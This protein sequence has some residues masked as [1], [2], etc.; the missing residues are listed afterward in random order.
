MHRALAEV[1]D[2]DRRAWHLASASTGPDEQ[3]AA[4]L[5]RT[6]ESARSR[7]G[8]AAVAAAY[9][10]AA[11]LSAHPRERGR[12]LV[13]AARAAA[14]AGQQERAA[15]LA[16]DAAALIT[17]PVATA[18]VAKF[19][20]SLADERGSATSAHQLLAESAWAV[21][22][23]TPDLA[24]GLL[25][26]A[27][28]IAWTAGDFTAVRTAADQAH[29]LR[30]PD[31]GR[32]GELAARITALNGPGGD[33]VEAAIA[34]HLLLDRDL[35]AGPPGLRGNARIAWWEMLLGD[36]GA[37]HDR[38]VGL[39]RESRAQGAIG[40]LPR[41]LMLLARS[42]LWLGAHRDARSSA[43]EGVRVGGG[44]DQGVPEHQA[45]AGHAE[46][47]P[48][49][50]GLQIGHARA[51]PLGRAEHRHGVA[52][53]LG[54][55]H[56]QQDL[57]RLGQ[58]GDAV[59]ERLLDTA[60]CGEGARAVRLCHELTLPLGGE[61]LQHGQWVA[62]RFLEDLPAVFLD[63]KAVCAA[64]AFERAN[65]WTSGVSVPSV[66]MAR[67]RSSSLRTPPGRPGMLG[68]GAAHRLSPRS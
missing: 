36:Y 2:G 15:T 44:S 40:V 13:H 49:L 7:G 16:D 14:D 23:Q 63:S 55:G 8:H 12:R 4:E 30:V 64:A 47:A 20:A 17:E 28:E 9:E 50:G 39:E 32:I 54:G 56:Q 45:V 53:L 62:L 10:R 52:V 25:F 6:A 5:E 59:G 24:A 68:P 37:A 38:A 3:V 42:Q 43:T 46:Q 66:T 31:A 1:L 34:V 26:S 57:R 22:G 67:A 11:K 51:E 27:V 21:A 61:Q 58:R 29:R 35:A 19:R 48:V 65:R 33:V 60:E 41:A 18:E